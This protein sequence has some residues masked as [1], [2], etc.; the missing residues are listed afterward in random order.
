MVY[1]LHFETAYRHAKHYTG[2]CEDGRLPER[3]EEHRTGRGAQLMEVV[4][5]AG[6]SFRLARTWEGDRK[7]ERRKKH[8]G[9]SRH[10]PLCQAARRVRG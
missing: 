8:R 4:T 2:F 5:G 9:A 3:L 7:T 10:C 1:L 6:I